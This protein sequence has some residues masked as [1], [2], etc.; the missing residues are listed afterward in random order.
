MNTN[1]QMYDEFGPMSSIFAGGMNVHEN[2][3]LTCTPIH[4]TCWLPI[5]VFHC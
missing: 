2:N 5:A 3:L 4:H 1:V